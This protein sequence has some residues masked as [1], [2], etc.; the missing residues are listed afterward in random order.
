M[1][2]RFPIFPLYRRHPEVAFALLFATSV[3]MAGDKRPDRIPPTADKL[4]GSLTQIHPD[5][6]I[7]KID[8][9]PGEAL[10]LEKQAREKREKLDKQGLAK[11][12][13]SNETETEHAKLG[14]VQAAN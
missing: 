6:T 13:A 5:G 9:R 11:S 1:T 3:T 4:Q 14:T 12:P 7:T 10:E 2:T 8:C